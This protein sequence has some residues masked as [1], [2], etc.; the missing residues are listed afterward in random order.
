MGWWA[1]FEIWGQEC[2]TKIKSS[3]QIL[4]LVNLSHCLE[5]SLEGFQIHWLLGCVQCQQDQTGPE[6]LG[7]FLAAKPWTVST[8]NLEVPLFS[9]SSIQQRVPLLK[10]FPS[11][12]TLGIYGPGENVYS[13]LYFAHGSH[14]I[15][16]PPP[17]SA[18]KRFHT[19]SLNTWGFFTTGF[20]NVVPF[21]GSACKFDFSLC[22][23]LN[24]PDSQN[25]YLLFLCM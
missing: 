8:V 23:P 1:P 13:I 16:I 20:F 25:R 6:Y 9:Q 15:E 5:W 17:H 10:V 7:N 22:I 21:W 3:R 19:H 4:Q 18:W 14:V 12:L 2:Q 24:I 11:L